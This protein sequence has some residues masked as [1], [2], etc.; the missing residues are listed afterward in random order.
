MWWIWLEVKGLIEY[1]L[2]LM[3]LQIL[4][5]V[6]S[7]MVDVLRHLMRILIQTCLS[8]TEIPSLQES[9]LNTASNE[10]LNSSPIIFSDPMGSTSEIKSIENISI[11][12]AG[13][14]G[15]ISISFKNDFF[16]VNK[17]GAV[18]THIF[19]E[20]KDKDSFH[21][22]L[23]IMQRLINDSGYSEIEKTKMSNGVIVK[24]KELSKG[25]EL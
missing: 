2:A 5:K 6:Y 8:L 7:A 24:L 13:D 14:G 22:F 25:L 3:K 15:D 11:S 23:D 9:L 16:S 19:R 18:N 21:N 20:I 12:P 17:D 4:T 1:L 10:K